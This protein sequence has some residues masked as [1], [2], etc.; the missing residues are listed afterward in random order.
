MVKVK[1][2]TILWNVEDIKMSHVDSYIVSRV[3]SDIETEY[4]NIAKLTI[5][6]GKIRKYLRMTIDY[7]S[8][9]KV[10]LYMINCIGKN[11][12]GTIKT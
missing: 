3:L 5:T 11:L 8:L 6:H 12:D 2:F 4:G 7:S 1:Q 9:V 10:N